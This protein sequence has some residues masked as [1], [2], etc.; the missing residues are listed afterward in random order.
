MI[1]TVHLTADLV[2]S[3]KAFHQMM[4]FLCNTPDGETY[5]QHRREGIRIN[6]YPNRKRLNISG[7]LIRLLYDSDVLNVDDLYGSNLELFLNRIDQYLNALF[8]HPVI[9]I[10]DFRV[11]RIDYCFNIKTP[12]VKLYLDFL[13]T[14]FERC[15]N[16]RRV[17]HVREHRLNGSVY[18]KTLSDYENDTLRNYALNYYDKLSRLHALMDEGKPVN[19][20]DLKAA[21]DMLR[22]EVQC[23]YQIIKRLCK[24]QGVKLSFGNMLSYDMAYAAERMVYAYVFRA[25]ETQDFF[26]YAEAAKRVPSR[27][28]VAKRALLRASQN[29]LITGSEFMYGRTVIAKASVY[30]FCFLPKGSKTPLLDNPL[31]LISAKLSSFD[32]AQSK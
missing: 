17:N 31:K 12:H 21:E 5:V 10:R 23:G 15:N 14:A 7:K 11:R 32:T 8:T 19:A 2:L 6:Y 29:H 20:D 3:D 4:W 24:A 13:N 9:S 1:D 26:T 28:S 16:G 18:V 30:P 22:L 25:D 27:S